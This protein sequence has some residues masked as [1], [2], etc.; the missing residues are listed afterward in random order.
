MSYRDRFAR[1]P[2]PVENE[3]F[4]LQKAYQFVFSTPEGQ[5]VLDD[6]CQRL[7][8]LDAVVG[9]SDPIQAVAIIERQN[10]AKQIARLALG[11]IV[12]DNIKRTT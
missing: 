9:Y 12:D 1:P 5:R 6:I 3:N 2:T 10:V 11:T 7:C 8:G 4:K